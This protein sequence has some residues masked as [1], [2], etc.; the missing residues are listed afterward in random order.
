V[1][2]GRAGLALV[3]AAATAAANPLPVPRDVR[4]AV[5]AAAVEVL[6]ARCGGV[7]VGSPRLV[8]TALHCVRPEE[9]DRLRVRFRD[10]AEHAAT[11]VDADGVADQAVLRL[12]G[13]AQVAPLEVARRPPIVGTVL[14]FAG[15]P[16]RPNWQDSRLDR[17]G[18]CPSL[19]DLP[20]ALFTDIAG[21]PGDSG[22]PLVDGAAQVVGLV[23]GGAHCHIATP[24]TRLAR[25]VAA[26][27]ARPDVR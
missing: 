23:H 13:P 10:G 16:D 5:T 25:L 6:P 19:P 27:L 24:G 11:F 2:A 18:T 3:L 14:Y 1:R 8:A 7:L 22:S 12:D 20:D 26:V 4:R 9:R 17:I 21:I 15:N